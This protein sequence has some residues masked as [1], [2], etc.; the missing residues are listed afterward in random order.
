MT[1]AAEVR[2]VIPNLFRDLK[3]ER[4]KRRVERST[5]WAV[6]LLQA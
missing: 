4:S 1:R 3:A 2:E 6:T 5:A